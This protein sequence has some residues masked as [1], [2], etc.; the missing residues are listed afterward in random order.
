[1]QDAV[2]AHAHV[3]HM[4]FRLD[5]DVGRALVHGLGQDVVD[6][7]DDRGFFG[8]FAQVADV[9][10]HGVVRTAAAAPGHVQQTVQ[11]L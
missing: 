3:E 10:V 5:M 11:V 2:G 8:Q 6:Q 1:M 7:L 9:I 4:L